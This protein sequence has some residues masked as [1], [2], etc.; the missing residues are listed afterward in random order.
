MPASGWTSYPSGLWTNKSA[1]FD[2]KA[3]KFDEP[4]EWDGGTL[5]CLETAFV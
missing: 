4:L 1:D 3:L 5:G 2:W